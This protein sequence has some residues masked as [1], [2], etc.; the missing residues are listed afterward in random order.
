MPMKTPLIIA[1]VGNLIDMVSTLYLINKGY[2]EAN[3]FMAALLPYP[4]LFSVVKI[5][6]M[7]WVLWILWKSREYR[8]ARITAWIAAVVY[9]L[10]SVY[11]LVLLP[12]LF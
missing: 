1:G 4:L 12:I 5:G 7:G 8:T 2:T 3:P 9:G 10:I 6:A 11:Y